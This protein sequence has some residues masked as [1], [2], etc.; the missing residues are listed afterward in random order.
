MSLG[1]FLRNRARPNPAVD[2]AMRAHCER[3]IARAL[4]RATAGLDAPP[5][6]LLSAYGH[7]PVLTAG[8]P[9][10]TPAE[11]TRALGAA[12]KLAQGAAAAV[13]VFAGRRR[14]PGHGEAPVETVE[15]VVLRAW[16]DADEAFAWPV[17]R[18]A[19]GRGT[20]GEPVR[21]DGPVDPELRVLGAGPN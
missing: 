13:L 10:G 14:L 4:A 17:R 15:A 2:P 6:L 21:L 16:T 12:R 7:G 3:F 18:D 1:A 9:F 5:A 19:A 8:L 11:R 20:A